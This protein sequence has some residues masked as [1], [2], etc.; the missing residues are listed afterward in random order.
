MRHALAGLAYTTDRCLSA[1]LGF[2]GVEALDSTSNP[3]IVGAHLGLDVEG[4]APD[5]ITLGDLVS[6]DVSLTPKVA[7][8]ASTST[9][10]FAQVSPAQPPTSP[11]SSAPFAQLGDR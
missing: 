1:R 11:R 8:Q 6:G 4:S 9:C 7:R 5:K 3:T 2:L 10:T